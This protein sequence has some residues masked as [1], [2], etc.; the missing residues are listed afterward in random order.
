MHAINERDDLHRQRTFS[1]GDGHFTTIKIENGKLLLWPMHQARL[2]LANRALSIGE[3]AWPDL[4]GQCH[5]LAS[6]LE[7]GFM[8]VLISRGASQRGYGWQDDIQ[9][10]VFI[11]F[12]PMQLAP[13]CELN[14][15]FD[16]QFLKTQLGLNPKSA[17]LKHCNRLEQV[18]IQQELKDVNLSD[19]LVTDLH[20]N[21]IEASKGNIFW[22]A[23]G[24]WYTP[25]LD[26]AGVQG[27]CRNQIMQKTEGITE[28]SIGQSD[29]LE[30]AQS[31]FICN[32]LQGITPIQKLQSRHLEMQP[33]YELHEALM[34]Q[35]AFR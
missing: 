3:V 24:Q 4:E 26:M 23:E 20:K 34:K 8:K 11:D 9:P 31:A 10:N 33:V 12:G 7:N 19:G 17:G 35:G 30:T 22:Y 1:F 5:Q 32:A 27:V 2:E 21:V 25:K 28:T 15:P 16:I 29:F 6:Q 14:L 13:F 18:F